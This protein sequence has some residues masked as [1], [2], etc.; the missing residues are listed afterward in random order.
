M[1]PDQLRKTVFVLPEGTEKNGNGAKNKTDLNLTLADFA[2]QDTRMVIEDVHRTRTLIEKLMGSSVAPRK[3]WLMNTNWD[4][5][6]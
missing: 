5:E 3:E 1:N 2:K 6:E 4:E